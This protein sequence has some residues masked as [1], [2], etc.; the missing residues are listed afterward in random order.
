MYILYN[1][2]M[3]KDKF[4]EIHMEEFIIKSSDCEKLI[5]I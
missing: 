1:L 2:I 4:S 5:G 3:T